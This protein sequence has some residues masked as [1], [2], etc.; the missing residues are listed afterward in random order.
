[1]GEQSN[2]AFERRRRQRFMARRDGAFCF[3]VVIEGGRLPVLDLSVEGFAV[4]AETP[5]QADRQFV[6]AL[7]RN[8]KEGEVRGTA[9]M[10]NFVGA[11]A[12]GQAG[13]VIDRFEGD[14]LQRLEAWLCEHVL[15]VAAVPISPDE[16]GQIVKG[17][18]LV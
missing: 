9:R 8:G 13:C 16:A 12:G 3:S 11:L 17:P 7:R 5:P 10:V 2:P 6:F 15:E 18:S 1:M 4:P 14:G